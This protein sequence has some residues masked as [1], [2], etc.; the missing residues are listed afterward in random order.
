M[1]SLPSALLLLALTNPGSV[2]MDTEPGGDLW[3][4]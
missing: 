4:L 2:S 1:G 3:D